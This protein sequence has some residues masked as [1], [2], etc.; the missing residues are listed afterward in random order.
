MPFL[1]QT[2]VAFAGVIVI[3]IIG[4]VAEKRKVVW[5]SAFGN[6][7]SFLLV[8]G[9]VDMGFFMAA[10]LLAYLVLGIFVI[11]YKAKPLYFLFGF[12]TYGALSLVLLLA[13]GGY[14]GLSITATTTANLFRLL[15]I[16][17]AFAV[18]IHIIGFIYNRVK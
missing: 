1:S 17:A 14:I 11:Y 9:S 4:I 3:I 12:K 7:M 10:G 5:E 6:I 8:L 16:W 15:G 13:S 2:H 18:A